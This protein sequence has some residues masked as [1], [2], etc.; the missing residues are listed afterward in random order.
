MSRIS[1]PDID[2]DGVSLPRVICPFDD[3]TFAIDRDSCEVHAAKVNMDRIVVK[4]RAAT[5]MYRAIEKFGAMIGRGDRQYEYGSIL[6]D[7]ACI[8]TKYILVAR[9]EPMLSRAIVDWG[10]GYSHDM[11]FPEYVDA[12]CG[13]NQ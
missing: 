12:L 8:Q 6:F 3:I 9:L 11:T 2:M 10:I 13:E 7:G 4:S 1:I 5:K